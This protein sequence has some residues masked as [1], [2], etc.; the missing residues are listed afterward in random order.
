MPRNQPPRPIRISDSAGRIEC[1]A[2]LATIGRGE[3]LRQVH[4]RAAADRQHRPDEPEHDQEH[5]RDD[6]VG[7]RVDAHRH[8]ADQLQA[9]A[10]LVV[11]G[12]PAEQVAETPGDD[13]CRHEEAR[14]P[15][16]CTAD[17]RRDGGRKGRQRGPE[18]GPQDAAPEVRV[19]LERRALQAVELAQRLPHRFDGVRSGVAEGGRGRDRLLDRID[20]RRVGDHVGEVDADERHEGELRQTLAEIGE[21]SAHGACRRLERSGGTA[22]AGT[23]AAAKRPI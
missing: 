11:A 3:A 13:R 21:I 8:D 18:I 12:E 2:T 23:A 4:R 9:G 15:R 20:R 10:L 16:Q 6:V 22:A 1:S 7:D 14:G 17:Q 5:E 19:L